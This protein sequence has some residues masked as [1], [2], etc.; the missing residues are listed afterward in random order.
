MKTMPENGEIFKLL[1]CCTAEA[2]KANTQ[3]KEYQSHSS[4]LSIQKNSQPQQLFTIFHA[5]ES[6]FYLFEH[7]KDNSEQ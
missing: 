7:S 4:D 5:N 2:I 3:T 6:S 1:L